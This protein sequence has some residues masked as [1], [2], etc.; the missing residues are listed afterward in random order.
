MGRQ[1][2]QQPDGKF[3]IWSTNSDS[4]IIYDASE[5]DIITYF[6]QQDIKDSV[7]AT[8]NI[9]DELKNGETPY[10]QFTRTWEEAIKEHEERHGPLSGASIREGR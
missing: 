8:M 9:L 6:L 7:A 10:Y 4:I 5:A 1:I 3:A 2:I